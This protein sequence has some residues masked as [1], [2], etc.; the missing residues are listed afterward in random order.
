MSNTQWHNVFNVHFDSWMVSMGENL[1]EQ[2]AKYKHSN[3]NMVHDSCG[4]HW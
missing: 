1:R 4:K 2:F 3:Y